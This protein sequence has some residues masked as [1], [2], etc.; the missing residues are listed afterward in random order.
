MLCVRRECAEGL[1]A[2]IKAPLN[3]GCAAAACLK[4]SCKRNAQ[5]S[6]GLGFVSFVERD[7][8]QARIQAFSG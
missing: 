3:M 1:A 5:P 7:P 2:C 6:L 4:Q 8:I